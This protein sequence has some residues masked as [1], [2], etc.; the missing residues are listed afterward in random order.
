MSNF[1]DSH[2]KKLSNHFDYPELELRVLLNKASNTDKEIFFSNFN[3]EKI[4]IQIFKD[5][6]D[7][8]LKKEP[9]SKIFNSKEFWKYNFYVNKFVL[10]PRPETETL[11][12]AILNYS[13]KK[14]KILDLG[15][16]SGCIAIS[17]ALELTDATIVGVD[18][19]KAAL[20]VARKNS[21]VTGANVSFFQSNC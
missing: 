8:R 16:G 9:I 18:I 6:F 12:E 10:D 7:R 19:S 13:G 17:L 11:V 20:T 5:S 4:N 3:I 14:K 2:L 21:R 15:T 1:L